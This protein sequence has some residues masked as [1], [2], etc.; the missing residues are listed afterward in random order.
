MFYRLSQFWPNWKIISWF[1]AWPQKQKETISELSCDVTFKAEQISNP[2]IAFHWLNKS[3]AVC[4]NASYYLQKCHL[5][6]VIASYCLQKHQ[7]ALLHSKQDFKVVTWLYLSLALWT[8]QV[9]KYSTY[10]LCIFI[11]GMK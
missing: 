4:C 6:S 11:L 10:S 5:S 3:K 9:G 8:K 7:L 2:D 1:V